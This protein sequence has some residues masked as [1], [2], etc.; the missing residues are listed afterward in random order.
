M[1]P[2]TLPPA[3][4]DAV[5]PQ[6]LRVSRWA[7]GHHGVR[8]GLLALVGGF[9]AELLAAGLAVQ[10]ISVSLSDFHPEVVGRQY[11]WNKA[12]GPE[13]IDRQYT[14]RRSDAYLQSPVKVIH[15][16]AEAFRRRLAGPFAQADLPVLQELRDAGA[17]DF[18]AFALKFTDG[19][20]QYISFASDAPDG[21]PAAELAFL[22]TLLP[23]LCLRIEIEHARLVT[24]QLLTVYLGRT[25]APRV[26]AGEMRRVRG[27]TIEAVILAADMRDFTHLADTLSPDAVF[28][29]LSVF[30]DALAAPTQAAGGDVIKMIADGV[31]AVFPLPGDPDGQ[32]EAAVRAAKAARDAIS[33]LAALTPEDLPPGVFPLRAGIALHEGPVTFGNV[34]SRDRLDFT[35]IGP[36]VNEAFRIEALTKTLKRPVLLSSAFARLLGGGT[37][38]LGQ[39]ALKGVGEPAEIFAPA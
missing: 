2:A 12:A 24:D 19:T 35:L 17:T 31:L 28:A 39:H 36:A 14:L 34:G 30:Y 25:A 33:A 16:G 10:R 15:D 11:N 38:S 23:Q 3:Y 20:R 27:E 21:F 13:R 18:V 9:G 26:L 29:A 32:R 4:P 37:I 6:W 8:E 7:A 22:E 1:E 5:P